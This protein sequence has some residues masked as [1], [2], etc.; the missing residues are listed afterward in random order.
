L[1]SPQRES[2]CGIVGDFSPVSLTTGQV[3]T[4][5]SPVRHSL[6]AKDVRL[7]CVRHAASVYPEPGSNSPCKTV[8]PLPASQ[9]VVAGAVEL[10]SRP[11]CC[12]I[13]C[14]HL[15]VRRCCVR[16]LPDGTT[17]T[18]LTGTAVCDGE[19]RL[20]RQLLFCF[21]LFNCQ[22][23]FSEWV[24]RPPL[25]I[26]Y[27]DEANVPKWLFHSLASVDELWHNCGDLS[28]GYF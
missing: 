12:L 18:E 14:L 11:S 5:Y 10:R 15:A 19:I 7:A 17:R 25:Y 4:C 2:L 24:R 3:P 23:T 6:L 1:L 27:S 22:G 20:D 28:R 26:V 21:P 8:S 16:L 13:D 9:P